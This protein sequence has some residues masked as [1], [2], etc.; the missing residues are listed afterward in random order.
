VELDRK[1]GEEQPRVTIRR[2]QPLDDLAKRS[3][4][5]L[6]IR[7]DDPARAPALAAELARAEGGGT[8]LARLVTRLADGREAVL[9][10]GKNY[11]LDAE[12]VARL[13]RIT[14]EGSVSL[15][16]AEPLRLVG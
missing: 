2:F 13:E 8:G 11:L 12:L 14:G 4:L 16:V 10:L 5:E 3:R 6:V 15:D 9:L 1:P 7:S